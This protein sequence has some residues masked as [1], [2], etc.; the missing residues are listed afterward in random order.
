MDVRRVQEGANGKY[1]CEA[2]IPYRELPHP[3][4]DY[5]IPFP[6]WCPLDDVDL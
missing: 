1:V 5:K 3:E 4:G 2:T 6:K